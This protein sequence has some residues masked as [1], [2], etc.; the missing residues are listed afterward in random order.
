MVS[1]WPAVMTGLLLAP[2]APVL[3]RMPREAPA[4]SVVAPLPITGNLKATAVGMPPC[5]ATLVR[6]P[7]PRPTF[8]PPAGQTPQIEWE[9]KNTDSRRKSPSLV[10]HVLINRQTGP[11][12]PIPN[13]PQRGSFLDQVM[14]TELRPGGKTTGRL[15][16]PITQPGRYLVE[17]EILNES[18]ERVA[19]AALNLQQR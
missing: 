15:K 19:L 9:V 17:L 12:Q 11:E 4:P 1:V 18:G 2:G 10:V 16:V 6:K 7:G 14:G 3:K 5:V 13:S 8:S